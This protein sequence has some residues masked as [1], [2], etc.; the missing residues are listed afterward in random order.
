MKPN[1]YNK[2]QAEQGRRRIAIDERSKARLDTFR[3][4]LI[5]WEAAQLTARVEVELGG[6]YIKKAGGDWPRYERRVGEIRSEVKRESR[7]RYK[8]RKCELKSEAEKEKK[9]LAVYKVEKIHSGTVGKGERRVDKRLLVPLLSA[10]VHASLVAV[11][12]QNEASAL[13]SAR[14]SSLSASKAEKYGQ[15]RAEL[16]RVN[17]KMLRVLHEPTLHFHSGS[18]RSYLGNGTLAMDE[19]QEVELPRRA[20]TEVF[21]SAPRP[22][23]MFLEP[24]AEQVLSRFTELEH[25]AVLE[26]AFQEF[27]ARE[28]AEMMQPME[29]PTPLEPIDYE[30]LLQL[31]GE[32]PDD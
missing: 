19:E 32:Y 22:A 8:D 20:T 9:A 3:Q 10:A 12:G 27:E 25:A 13:P 14:S 17:K 5:V 24:R 7:Q 30:A 29:V 31:L 23:P 26:E 2:W 6:P 1:D 21:R 16:A 28:T 15:E 11:G 4:E 18:T